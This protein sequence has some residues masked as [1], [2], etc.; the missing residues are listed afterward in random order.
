MMRPIHSTLLGSVT[1]A[2]VMS[3]TMTPRV[4]SPKLEMK[5]PRGSAKACHPD[6]TQRHADL[7]TIWALFFHESV[8]KHTNTPCFVSPRLRR[9]N[10]AVIGHKNAG[11]PLP[12][13]HTTELHFVGVLRTIDPEMLSSRLHKIGLSVQYRLMDLTETYPSDDMRPNTSCVMGQN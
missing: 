1:L 10:I 3:P 7:Q 9:S 5:V 4:A 2:G 6:E 11:V 12:S 13:P 8:K